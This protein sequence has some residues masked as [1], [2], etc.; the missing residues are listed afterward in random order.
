MAKLRNSKP[1]NPSGGF[2]RLFN[3][4]AL[5]GL[6]SKVQS[7]VIAN[8]SELENL[9]TARAPAVEDLAGRWRTQA[10]VNRGP[11]WCPRSR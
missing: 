3:D 11:I 7:T 8:G 4:D 10:A 9:I 6:M 2:N 1:R 5:G